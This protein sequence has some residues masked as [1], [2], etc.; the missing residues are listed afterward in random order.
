MIKKNL[1]ERRKFNCGAIYTA[2]DNSEKPGKIIWW[3]LHFEVKWSESCS[4]LCDSLQPHGLYSPWNSVGQN[5]GVGSL[6][7]LLGIF[8][9]RDHTKFPTL[10]ADSIPVEPQGKHKNTGVGSLSLLQHI[11]PTQESNQGL[12]H[13]RPIVYQLGYQGSP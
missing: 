5:N 6:F 10:Q 8:Q 7:L 12:L 2:N 13:C 11:L 4:V 1:N 9:P 3:L